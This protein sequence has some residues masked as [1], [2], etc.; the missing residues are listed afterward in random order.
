MWER[1]LL[2]RTEINSTAPVMSAH[3][4]GI[5]ALFANRKCRGLFPAVFIDV[6][7]KK[8]FFRRFALINYVDRVVDDYLV[9]AARCMH[10]GI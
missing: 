5:A 6:E 4:A 2:K 9:H 8:A 3:R 10:D 7:R 1:V